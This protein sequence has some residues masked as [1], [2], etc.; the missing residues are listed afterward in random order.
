MAK[1]G[2]RFLDKLDS[3]EEKERKETEER[4]RATAVT[5]ST[6]G[7]REVDLSALDDAFVLDFGETWP[8]SS[9][10]LANESDSC[11]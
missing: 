5:P 9:L 6:I 7:F 3:V 10:T 2:L 1:R 4:E 11:Y 8:A